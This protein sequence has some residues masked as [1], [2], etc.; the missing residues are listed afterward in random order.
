[1]GRR[2]AARALIKASSMV[3]DDCE[4]KLQRV[5]TPDKWKDG[6]RNTLGTPGARACDVTEPDIEGT[7]SGGRKVGATSTTMMGKSQAQRCARR[8]LRSSAAHGL[9]L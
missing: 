3:C 2:S 4:K 7:E 5:I 9:V 1:M 8:L 6:A